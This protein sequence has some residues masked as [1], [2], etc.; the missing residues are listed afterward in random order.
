MR[1]NGKERNLLL[2]RRASTNNGRERTLVEHQL[3]RQEKVMRP[4]WNL[5]WV[6]VE[7]CNLH[8]SLYAEM[9]SWM[10]FTMR[11]NLRSFLE[12]SRK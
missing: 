11:L 1:R 8:V 10:V 3:A 4:S 12:S 7:Q 6:Q 9:A 2:Q 5:N